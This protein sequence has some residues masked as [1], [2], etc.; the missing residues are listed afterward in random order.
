M[1]IIIMIMAKQ[2]MYGI[3]AKIQWSIKEK[4]IAILQYHA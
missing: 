4:V 3:V 1:H 2:K